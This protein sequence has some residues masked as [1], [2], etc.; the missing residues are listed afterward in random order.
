[1][2]GSNRDVLVFQVA[3]RCWLPGSGRRVGGCEVFE[4]S[5]M[6]QQLDQSMQVLL[7]VPVLHHPRLGGCSRVGLTSRCPGPL[8]IAS[9]VKGDRF[10]F[11]TAPR[12]AGRRARE[13]C[14]HR[15]ER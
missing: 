7:F 5:A 14:P 1:M 3:P 4:L 9:Q 2:I 15:F 12:T 6:L 11:R 8:K 10:P 13:A